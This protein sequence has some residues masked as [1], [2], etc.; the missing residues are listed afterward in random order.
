MDNLGTKPHTLAIR[1]ALRTI[2]RKIQDTY[3][4][5]MQRIRDQN[6]DDANLAMRT[7][8]WLTYTL[9]PLTIE[10]LQHALTVDLRSG[11][12]EPDSLV[13]RDD[14]ISVCGGIVTLE[15]ESQL[16][17]FIHYT[18]Q[19]Y[20]EGVRGNIFPKAQLEITEAC[21]AYLSQDKVV[22]QQSQLPFF[23]YAVRNWGFHAGKDVQKTRR[24]QIIAFIER[25][26]STLSLGAK[27]HCQ[28]NSKLNL[29]VPDLPS[30]HIATYFN[31]D[32]IL[33]QL[34]ENR[35]NS[36]VV[37]KCGRTILHDAATFRNWDCL[38][39]LWDAESDRETQLLQLWTTLHISAINGM[40]ELAKFV[41]IHEPG[42]S[43]QID[44]IATINR[45]WT[46]MHEAASR[47][48]KAVVEILYEEGF[49]IKVGR[50]EHYPF[51]H[52]NLQE[53]PLDIQ[54][55]PREFQPSY[56]NPFDSVNALT[57]ARIDRAHR[58]GDMFN[59]EPMEVILEIDDEEEDDFS[60][61]ICYGTLYEVTQ[62]LPLLQS[63]L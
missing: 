17:R 62:I 8:S 32:Q 59:L 24:E 45:G 42:L 30:V 61:T 14:I 25:E 3:D 7:L 10:E 41:F 31:L 55:V 16:I 52:V 19:E 58:Y 39:M 29:R 28:K 51:W 44:P 57:Q 18:T 13:E 37:D 40:P 56:K 12:V 33:Q 38:K 49:T 15:E 46:V 63:D 36:K 5:V 9:E 6:E 1:E 22:E 50:V 34:L 48:H 35:H 2:P 23:S 60:I 53:N 43:K 20:L 27:R 47:N 54:V 26:R 4:L 21:M 11:S